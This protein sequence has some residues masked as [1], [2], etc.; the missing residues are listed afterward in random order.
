MAPF[1]NKVGSLVAISAASITASATNSGVGGPPTGA[2]D[3]QR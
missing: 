2:N 1:T 3:S